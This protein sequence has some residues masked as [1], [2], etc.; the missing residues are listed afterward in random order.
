MPSYIVQSP[1]DHDQ[2]RYMPGSTVELTEEQ[3]APLLAAAVV[4]AAT[5]K[6]KKAE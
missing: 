6:K 2:K 4:E 1:L 3:A 5:E